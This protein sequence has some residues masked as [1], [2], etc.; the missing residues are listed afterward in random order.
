MIVAFAAATLATTP[1]AQAGLFGGGKAASPSP[2]PSASAMPAATPE[3]PDIAI[4]RL[5]AK[6]KANPNDQAAM[7]ELA[8]Q[9]LGINRPD[10]TVQ[11]TQHLLQMGD[12]TAQVYYLEGY[13]MERLGRTDVAISDLEQAE[14]LD[15]S[16]SSV[17]SNLADI[18][19]RVNRAA[20][21][22]RIAKRA[23]TLNKDDAQSYATYGAVYAAEQKFDDARTQFE[24][25]ASLSPKDPHPIFQIAQTYAQQ[26]NIPMALQTLARALA[27]DPSNVQALVFKADLYAKQHDDAKA[28][29]AYD[30]AVVAAPDENQ[31]VSILVRK[32][33]Y[34]V[35]EKKPS[36]AES[37][38][39]QMIAQYPKNAAGHAAYGDFLASQKNMTKA[40][41]EWQAALA[42]DKDQPEALLRMAQVAMSSNHM[43]DAIGYLKHL[44]QVAP[45]AQ[46]YA[47]LGQA[48]S[49]THDYSHSKDAC[50]KSFQ[51][52]QQPTT[53]GCI[54]GADFELKNYKE[55]S[56]I[57]DA[58]DK[59]A[60]GFL[61]QNPQLLY[62]A[63]KSYGATNQKQKGIAAYKR[64]L[65]EMRKGTKDYAQV[66]KAIADLSKSKH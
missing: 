9:F 20:D 10:Y 49:F 51:I 36:D 7:T 55:A 56:R 40:Q 41:Q 60:R 39:A 34:L 21:A 59:G 14:N 58:L 32:A 45:D 43:T 16:N 54:A 31:K 47:M 66:Q 2:S 8:G 42:I 3:P 24:K 17:L 23:V 33:Q 4:P 57:F 27:I 22:E 19:L 1:S 12:K 5:Q 6:L 25:A 44:T 50:S 52:D 64:L 37:V 35:D 61:D 29:P 26:N 30:D 28:L 38:F 11:L 65:A 46:G 53:L 62:M 13:A 48:Y 63:G 18:Y 15:P